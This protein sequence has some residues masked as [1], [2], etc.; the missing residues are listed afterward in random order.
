MPLDKLISGRLPFPRGAHCRGCAGISA[1]NTNVRDFLSSHVQT[2]WARL[3]FQLQQATAA[4]SVTSGQ[5]GHR[6]PPRVCAWQMGVRIIVPRTQTSRPRET[7][8]DGEL[9]SPWA[10]AGA[11]EAFS[12]QGGESAEEATAAR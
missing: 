4:G 2:A 5:S 1:S 12:S 9:S 8:T 10:A 3:H 11:Q 7:S 6:G